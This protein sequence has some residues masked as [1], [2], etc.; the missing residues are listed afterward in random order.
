MKKLLLATV[1]AAAISFP[2]MAAQQG[3]PSSQSNMPNKSSWQSEQSGTTGQGSS[4]MQK[5]QSGTSS[6]DQNKMSNESANKS[7]NQSAQQTINPDSLDQSQVRQIQ[8][9][10]D[11]KGFEVGKTD[12]KWGPE[13]EAALRKFQQ[14]QKMSS[15]GQLDEQTLTQLGLNASQFTSQTTG[16]GSQM[17]GQSNGQMQKNNEPMKNQGTSGQSSGQNHSNENYK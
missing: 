9:A 16:Q 8:Q 2:A 3:N 6:A 5:S 14:D 13:T 15:P 17:N 10:L 4:S 11:K 12:G 7:S 1:A